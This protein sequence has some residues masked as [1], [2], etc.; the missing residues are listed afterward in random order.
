MVGVVMTII[1]S[2]HPSVFG[3]HPWILPASL[4]LLFAGL[5]FWLTQYHWFQ[6]VLGLQRTDLSGLRPSEEIE[7]ALESVLMRKGVLPDSAN[8]SAATSSLAAEDLLLRD[9]KLD[10]ELYRVVT[11]PKGAFADMT[12]QLIESMGKEFAIGID[13]LVELYIV[14]VSTETQYIRDFCASVEIDGQ[15]IELERQKDFDA[16]DVNDIDY[17][18]C[19]DPD[20]DGSKFELEDRAERLVP[21]FASLP[22][23][24]DPRKPL[25]GWVRFV[26]K[27]TDP[28]KLE[29]NRTYEFKIVDSLGD[30]HPIT[31]SRKPTT[32]SRIS[33]HKK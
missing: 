7:R 11:A 27:E 26:L 25:E 2:T 24:L 8:A 18:Y 22:I 29:N 14:N 31:R 5:L 23:E 32:A 20:P 30:E 9:A 4:L 12:R 17:E 13:I 21:I 6:R 3:N 16:W 19:V 10:G 33:V 1:Q 15:R 28:K